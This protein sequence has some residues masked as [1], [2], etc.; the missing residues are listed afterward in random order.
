MARP[1]R[2][3]DPSNNLIHAF[4]AELRQLRAEAGNPK[5][6]QMQ[7]MSGRSRTALS[8]A[9]GGDHVPTWET[10]E[11]FVR[12]CGGD[13]GA[14]LLKW[15]SVQ[16]QL[17]QSGTRNSSVQNAP[18]AERDVAAATETISSK[19]DDVRHADR[20]D[21]QVILLQLWQEQRTQARQSEN[22]RTVMTLVVFLAAIGAIVYLALQSETDIVSVAVALAVCALGLF[23]ALI[24]AKYYERF[25][26][27]TYGAEH[28]Q[29]RLS[30]LY[31]DLRI[32]QL[33]SE[34]ERQHKRRYK[35]LSTIRLHH[36][37][38]AAHLS[39]ALLGGIV[40]IVVLIS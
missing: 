25:K 31:P 35:T 21:G 39:I 15:E 14:W 26:L 16:D 8:E 7:R 4:A 24:S 30:E 6:L 9:A 3:L 27:H 29:R 33:W 36:L 18:T 19:A 2:L 32:E 22:H 20:S 34:N 12:A 11:A 1:D 28:F 5:Y 17:S 38:V 37:W 10:T 23:G 13:V 40:A